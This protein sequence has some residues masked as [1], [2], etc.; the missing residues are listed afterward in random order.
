[1]FRIIRDKIL[2]KH[3]KKAVV[4]A[5]DWKLVKNLDENIKLFRE[6]FNNDDTIRFREFET[7]DSSPVKCCLVFIDGMVNKEIVNENIIKPIVNFSLKDSNINRKAIDIFKDKIII[8][9]AV[10]EKKDVYELLSSCLYGDAILLLDGFDSALLLDCKGWNTR[11]IEEPSSETIVRG[12]KEG[13]NEAIMTNLTLIRR[14]IR[15]T[16]LKFRFRQLGTCTKTKICIC[17]IEGLASQE[18][19]TEVNRRLDDIEI[20]AVLESGYIEELIKDSPLSPFT[21][22]GNTERP[23]IVAANLLEGR[24]ALIIDG[25]PHVLTLPHLFIEYFQANED[26]YHGFIYASINRIIRIFAFFL[27]TSVPAIY[28]ALT[29]FHQEMIPTPL[30]LSISAAREGVPF[31]TIVEAL[32]MLLAFEI[33]RETGIRLPKP[34]GST[35]SF[36]GALILGQSAVEARFVSAPIVIVTALT[37]ISNFLVPQMIGALIVVRLIFL[38]L[39]AF[40]GLYGYIFGVIGL[41]IHLM[42]MRS[43]GI[44]YMLNIG[45]LD[46]QDIK[47]TAIRVPWWI[48]YLR[49]KLIGD[50]NKV[51][52]T[53]DGLYEKR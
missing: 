21:T 11:A 53:N 14:K 27:S 36:V 34:A 41:F 28:V 10:K 1:M 31:P 18:I 3:R 39:S 37:G 46:M 33:L 42:S 8:S 5:E 22:I 45:S 7:K 47:D 32:F 23:D 35:I 20:D 24:V 38:L 29:T 17:Y 2:G 50:N 30:L 19:I 16:D 52:Q 25:T 48:M 26:Y 6:I 9:S 44:P 40:L 4:T 12:P 13:F 15:N 51:R 49:P 43:F